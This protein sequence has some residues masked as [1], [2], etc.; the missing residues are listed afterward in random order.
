[1]LHFVFPPCLPLR[2]AYYDEDYPTLRRHRSDSVNDCS[3]TEPNWPD[4]EMLERCWD[5]RCSAGHETAGQGIAGSFRLHTG[6]TSGGPEQIMNV[7]GAGEGVN[8]LFSIMREVM[9]RFAESSTRT[10]EV[11]CTPRGSCGHGVAAP[12]RLPT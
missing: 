8:A 6:G 4:Y 11:L 3:G 9:A 7:P 1:M 2:T 12:E 10:H 5:M